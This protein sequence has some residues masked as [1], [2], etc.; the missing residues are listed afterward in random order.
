MPITLA[1]KAPCSTVLMEHCGIQYFII[2]VPDGSIIMR[3]KVVF[4]ILRSLILSGETSFLTRTDLL[5]PS[6]SSIFVS[7]WRARP[8]RAHRS[9]CAIKMVR[10][11]KIVSAI[12]S[13]LWSSLTYMW[14][15]VHSVPADDAGPNVVPH[16]RGNNLQGVQKDSGQAPEGHFREPGGF[17]PQTA[18]FW[19]QRGVLTRGMM[20]MDW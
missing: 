11:I 16:H 12:T 1:L 20:A 4:Q 6:Q 14:L 9:M 3:Y 2:T 17:G 7:S 8:K 18:W 15:C 13:H 19:L 10:A 5:R